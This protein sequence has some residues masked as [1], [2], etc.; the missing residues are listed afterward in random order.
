MSWLQTV[1]RH[2]NVLII[3]QNN[4]CLVPLFQDAKWAQ[5][6][7]NK[8]AADGV[9]SQKDMGGRGKGPINAGRLMAMVENRHGASN[10]DD[11]T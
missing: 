11:G 9:N 7:R 6:W 10:A 3:L 1:D 5:I 4:K 8:G 2:S